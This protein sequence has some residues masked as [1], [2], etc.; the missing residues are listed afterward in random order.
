MVEM[1]QLHWKEVEK[2]KWSGPQPQRFNNYRWEDMVAGEV[3]KFTGNADG[4]SESVQ[5]N[6]GWLHLAQKPWKLEAVCE[7][8]KEPCIDGPG[9]LGDPC[10]SGVTGTDAGA[11]WLTEKNRERERFGE[12][13][14][15]LSL[16][17]SLFFKPIGTL[18]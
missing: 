11:A 5:D 8:W 14:L 17:L 9:C 13:L 15:S 1:E 3:S 2:D 10:A 18:L 16:S 4:L 7:M 6:T 12:H